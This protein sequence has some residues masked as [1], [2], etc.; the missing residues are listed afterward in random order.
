MREELMRRL[1]T[2]FSSIVHPPFVI[3]GDVETARLDAPLSRDD[4]PAARAMAISYFDTPPDEPISIVL[5]SG[6]EMYESCVE[7]LDGERRGAFAGCY[8]RNDHRIVVNLSTGD[9]TIAHELAHALGHFDFPAMPEWFDEGLASLHEEARF[10]KDHLRI[11]GIPNWRRRYLVS[12]LENGT[13]RP[14]ESL[15]A[16][17]RVRPNEQA[18]DYAHARYFCLFLQERGLLEPFYR[19]FRLAIGSDP[20][21][22]ADIARPVRRSRPRDNRRPVSRLGAGTRANAV[23]GRERRNSGRESATGH[24]AGGSKHRERSLTGWLGSTRFRS[25]QFFPWHAGITPRCAA[26]SVR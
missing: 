5:L 15:V 13:L 25:P 26:A 10:S 23:H 2:R 22:A 12:A 18:I 14:L 19:K 9:G 20:T 24:A 1:G 21:G 17:P 3:L 6:D 4:W 7:R 16:A 8:Q 11:V